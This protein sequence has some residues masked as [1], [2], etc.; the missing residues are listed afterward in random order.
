MWKF[1]L[2]K[3]GKSLVN[4]LRFVVKLTSFMLKSRYKKELLWK[5]KI[6][7]L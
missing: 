1:D 6:K 5:M 3:K 2:K 7:K 4:C